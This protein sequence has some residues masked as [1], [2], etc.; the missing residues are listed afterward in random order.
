[1]DCRWTFYYESKNPIEIY[2][3][4]LVIGKGVGNEKR[5][6]FRLLK[7]EAV[8]L[9]PE[10]PFTWASGIQSPIYCDNRLTLSYPDIRKKIAKG[11]ADVIKRNLLKCE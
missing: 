3:K 5:N 10:N 1:M 9:Q 4:L 2:H 6:H 8:A 7:I 11:L